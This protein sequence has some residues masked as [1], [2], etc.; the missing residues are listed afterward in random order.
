[1]KTDYKEDG[2][3]AGNAK[4][5]VKIMLKTMDSTT[6]SPERLEIS[7]LKKNEKGEMVHVMLTPDEIKLLIETCQKE[8]EAESKSSGDI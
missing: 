8:Q 2:A 3:L 4:L 7:E 6:L 1:M 5:A